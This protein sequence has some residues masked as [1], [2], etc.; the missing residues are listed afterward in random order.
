MVAIKQFRDSDSYSLAIAEREISFLKLMQGHPNL[1]KLLNSFQHNSKVFLVFE[2]MQQTLLEL[3]QGQPEGKLNRDQVRLIVYQM[4]KALAYMHSKNAVHRDIKPENMMLSRFVQTTFINQ[5]NEISNGNGNQSKR[6]RGHSVDINTEIGLGQEISIDQ[7]SVKDQIY[8][9]KVCDL[10][11]SRDM[12]NKTENLTEY[13]STRW[14]RAPELLVGSRN[15]DKSIDIWALGCIIPEL[16]SGNPIFPGKTNLETLAYIIRTFGNQMTES[17][18]QRFYENPEFKQYGKIPQVRNVVPLELRVP[19][20]SQIELDF[21]KKCLQFDPAQRLSAKE[22]LKHEYLKVESNILLQQ[23]LNQVPQAQSSDISDSNSQNGSLIKVVAQQEDQMESDQ[24]SISKQETGNNVK[25]ETDNEEIGQNAGSSSN[26]AQSHNESEVE[27]I[28]VNDS[29]KSINYSF[30]YKSKNKKLKKRPSSSGQSNATPTIEQKQTMNQKNQNVS[31]FNQ[32]IFANGSAQNQTEDCYGQEVLNTETNQTEQNFQ[33]NQQIQDKQLPK[34]ILFLRK[35]KEAREQTK[36]NDTKLS[37]Q[38]AF[39]DKNIHESGCNEMPFE[40]AQDSQNLQQNHLHSEQTVPQ[41]LNRFSEPN[42]AEY[43]ITQGT[44]AKL[45]RD[46]INFNNNQQMQP[47]NRREPIGLLNS[48]QKKTRLNDNIFSNEKPKRQSVDNHDYKPQAQQ[49]YTIQKNKVLFANLKNNQNQGGSPPIKLQNSKL[50]IN[51]LNQNQKN[52]HQMNYQQQ[53]YQQQA[54]LQQQNNRQNP[55]FI[56]AKLN[57]IKP[58]QIAQR[59]ISQLNQSKVS[60]P[61]NEDQF[62]QTQ[63]SNFG[64]KSIYNQQEN[65]SKSPS[66]ISVGP[67]FSEKNNQLLPQIH[68][69]KFINMPIKIQNVTNINNK[70]KSSLLNTQ[71]HITDKLQ[72]PQLMQNTNQISAS[73]LPNIQSSSGGDQTFRKSISIKSIQTQN[74]QNQQTLKPLYHASSQGGDS[75]SYQSSFV[76]RIGTSHDKQSNLITNS[77]NSKQLQPL[78][79]AKLPPSRGLLHIETRAAQYQVNQKTN[80]FNQN[81]QAT[82]SYSPPHQKVQQES[83]TFQLNRNSKW[84]GKSQNKYTQSEN[85]R[86]AK[87]NQA[88][89]SNERPN[90]EQTYF[91]SPP[92]P[93]SRSSMH[94]KPQVQQQS[95]ETLQDGTISTNQNQFPR[96]LNKPPK[97]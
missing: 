92:K 67:T 43:R 89:S 81:N 35:Q 5:P 62:K 69:E 91:N 94:N 42:Q 40:V 20:L 79:Q 54:M 26:A 32:N 57:Q 30:N 58:I 96:N 19:E 59:N 60:T 36:N 21:V 64:R 73:V 84:Y 23:Y 52:H 27:Q 22:L 24:N 17:Q 41:N 34:P 13:V 68:K 95:R 82:Q 33:Q 2:L 9:L 70:Q 51:N 93:M 75:Q 48:Q 86:L 46:K 77:A 56:D 45:T 90:N 87:I 6:Q 85:K 10:G 44:A 61:L 66:Q 83:Q 28:A 15:Y 97:R 80:N 53:L 16:I 37:E 12:L 55:K 47:Y 18:I 63:A 65:N 76:T 3:L 25:F 72:L 39:Y 88:T 38:K 8:I 31:N 1:I 74:Q 29:N 14:Y 4:V 7:D 71:K 78:N 11:Q 50:L 49:L